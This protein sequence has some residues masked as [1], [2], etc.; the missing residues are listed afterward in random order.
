MVRNTDPITSRLAALSV[1]NKHVDVKILAHVGTYGPKTSLEL[2]EEL[3]IA[4]V[5]ISPRLIHLRR[6]GLIHQEGTRKNRT[7][8]MACVWALGGTP[9]GMPRSSSARLCMY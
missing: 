7:G 4:Y 3:G 2:S 8:R 6:D 5:T 9:G 1:N